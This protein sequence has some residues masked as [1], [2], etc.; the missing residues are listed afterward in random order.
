M[1]SIRLIIYW[2]FVAADRRSPTG[3]LADLVDDCA[4][5][6]V[7]SALISNT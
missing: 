7:L 6:Q 1:K 4:A 5:R 2:L 3:E